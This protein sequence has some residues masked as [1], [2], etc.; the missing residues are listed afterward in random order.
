MGFRAVLCAPAGR[1][2]FRL[3]HVCFA[4]PIRNAVRERTLGRIGTRLRHPYRDANERRCCIED[5]LVRS[6]LR[7][8]H[9][10][11]RNHHD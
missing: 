2:P 1:R 11:R 7:H 4:I 10:Q 9:R 8:N 5:G 6:T 3:W